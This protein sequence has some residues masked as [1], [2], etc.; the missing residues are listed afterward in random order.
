MLTHAVRRE[1]KKVIRRCAEQ[2]VNSKI[3]EIKDLAIMH[4]LRP[5]RLQ[6]IDDNSF[7]VVVDGHYFMVKISEKV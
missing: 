6:S 1:L 3:A 7:Y 5:G 2:G 4:A